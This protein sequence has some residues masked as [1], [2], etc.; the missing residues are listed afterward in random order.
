MN[1]RNIQNSWNSFRGSL[2]SLWSR[3]AHDGRHARLRRSEYLCKRCGISKEEANRRTRD[4]IKDPG[5]LDDW[6]D[7]RSILDM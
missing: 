2:P 7:T 4:W 3:S 5:V 1:W 6:N